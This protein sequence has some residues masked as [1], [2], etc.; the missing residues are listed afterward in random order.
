MQKPSVFLLVA[1]FVMGCSSSSDN[2]EPP[3]GEKFIGEWGKAFCLRLSECNPIGFEAKYSAYS[4]AQARQNGCAREFSDRVRVKASDAEW[5]GPVGC[6]R[7]SAQAC[8]DGTY[9][10]RCEA[11]EDFEKNAPAICNGC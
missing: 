4:D 9:Q 6:A 7:S 2:D 10:L 5:S 8:V 11:F 1:G 3:T